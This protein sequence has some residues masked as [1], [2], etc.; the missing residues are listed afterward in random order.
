LGRGLEALIPVPAVVERPQPGEKVLEV[1]TDVVRANPFQPR[2]R[3]DDE[4][5]K[6]L[7]ESIK[8]DGILQPVVVR[9]KGADYELV[10]GE[11]RLQAA[12]LAGLPM[13]PVVIRDVSDADALRLAIVENI[14]RENLN[15]I[16]EAQAYRRLISEFNVSQAEVAGMVGK[17][18]SSVANTI[19]LLNLPEEVQRLIEDGSLTGGHGRALLSLPT[20]KEQLALARRIAEER[21]SVRQVEQEVGLVRVKRTAGGRR[22]KEKPPYLAELEK[23][24]SQHLATHVAIDEKRGGKGRIA[25]EFYSHDDFERLA[26]LMQV[27]L[28]R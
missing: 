18:R 22:R 24:F 9:R 4:R 8:A 5:L 19:R 14:Q 17:D 20:Q 27:P 6:E 13:I 21:M 7:S 26:L 11:R 1:P 25:I 15:A 3:I 16:E 12:R 23:A 10:M 2:K 28:P